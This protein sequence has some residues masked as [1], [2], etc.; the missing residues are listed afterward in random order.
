MNK[1]SL[2][3]YVRYDASGTVIP[4]SVILSRFKPK[5]GDWKEIQGYECCNPLPSN[6]VEF[7]VNA[8]QGDAVYITMQSDSGSA[9]Y[10]I[11]WGD[12]ETSSGILSD[13][14][15]ISHTYTSTELNY[16]ARICFSDPSDITLLEFYQD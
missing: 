12:G 10:N 15:N 14:V 1:R 11:V 7:T 16:T 8:P 3:A 5:V 6:C 13:P 4:S 2:K 9:I